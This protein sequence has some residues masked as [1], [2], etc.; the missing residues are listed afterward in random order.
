[1]FRRDTLQVLV[2]E[3]Y[4]ELAE[5][6]GANDRVAKAGLAVA[7]AAE[8]AA[9]VTRPIASLARYAGDRVAAVVAPDHAAAVRYAVEYHEAAGNLARC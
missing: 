6:L 7:V 2:A 4:A 1:M 3:T 8:G 5:L 9:E